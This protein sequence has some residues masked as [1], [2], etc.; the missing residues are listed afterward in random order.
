MEREEVEKKETIVCKCNVCFVTYLV[1]TRAII[2]FNNFAFSVA[3]LSVSQGSFLRQS[4]LALP[5]ALH[6]YSSAR[7]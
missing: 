1:P 3:A 6:D 5:H 7:I 4:G 2:T